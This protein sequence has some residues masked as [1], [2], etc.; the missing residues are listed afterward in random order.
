MLVFGAIHG[1]EQAGMQIVALLS[2]LPVPAGVDLFLVDTMNPDGVANDTRTNANGVDL[3]RNFPYNWGPIA[4]PGD[5]QYAG[6]A[7]PASRR[8]ERPSS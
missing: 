7:P 3:N 2:E 8:P 4:E 1:D 5:W 6:P